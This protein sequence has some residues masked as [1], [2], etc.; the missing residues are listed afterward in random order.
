MEIELNISYRRRFSPQYGE[1]VLKHFSILEVLQVSSLCEKSCILKDVYLRIG[2]QNLIHIVSNKGWILISVYNCELSM[3]L[4]HSG[5]VWSYILSNDW[6]F[7]VSM[8]V[9]DLWKD[10][11]VFI[12]HDFDSRFLWS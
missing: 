3:C 6:G 1:V 4:T 8:A 12:G 2:L 7:P 9:S 11:A 10:I 5:Y